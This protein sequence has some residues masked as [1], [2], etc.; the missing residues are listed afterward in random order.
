M[1]Q[2]RKK[3]KRKAVNLDSLEQINLNAAGLDIGAEE[4]YACVPEGRDSESV[5]CFG[6]FTVDLHALAKWLRQCGVTTVAMESTGVYWIPVYEVLTE[7]EFEVYL[8]NARHIKNV[9][10]KKS[11]VLDCQWIQQLHTY[12]LLQ[13]SFRPDE[14][15]CAVRA[16]VRHR[17]NLIR[18]RAAHIQH[19]QKALEQMNLKL[20]NVVADV[21]GLTGM[22]IIRAILRG[23][24]DPKQLAHYRH[25]GC[26][27][28][29]E[30]IAKAT[31]ELT[32]EACSV[33]DNPD[34]RNSLIQIRKQ[35]YQVIDTVSQDVILS[36]E[37]DKGV[38]EDAVKSFRDFMEENKDEI[39]ALQIIYNKPYDQRHL[40]YEMIKDLANAMKKP[41]YNLSSEV[42]WIAFE[43]LGKGKVK[44]R[45]PELML[46][47]IISLVRYGLGKDDKLVPYHDIVDERFN[48]W[49]KVQK[50]TGVSFDQE[51]LEWLSMIKD[52]IAT[53][54]QITVDDFDNVPF[55][56]KGG[57]MKV[58]NLFGD[59]FNS[60]IDELNEVL[61]A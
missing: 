10:G 60:I 40:T 50:Q 28:S 55:Y 32:N 59:K 2:K 34:F 44:K 57:V 3:Q 43:H 8:V 13:A 19:M 20:V 48:E 17:D 54:M 21:T 25:P 52:H 42:I 56:D 15:M 9:P 22:T 14:D 45:S 47:D 58:Y 37:F 12:G 35:Q 46:A 5:R 24:R 61:A 51:Q 36:T 29:E 31:E 4:I 27:K 26:R 41:P 11:D 53:S 1:S 16:L 33:F 6:T 18:Y 49:L 39:L 7:Y 38:A 30:Q 23:E